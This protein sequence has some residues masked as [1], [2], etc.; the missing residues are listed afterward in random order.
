MGSSLRVTTRRVFVGNTLVCLL[1]RSARDPTH[2]E[3]ALELRFVGDTGLTIPQSLLL[4]A[5]EVIQ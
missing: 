1:A 3:L 4:R 2:F 5:D